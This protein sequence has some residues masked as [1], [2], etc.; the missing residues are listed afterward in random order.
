MLAVLNGPRDSVG[1]VG[2]VRHRHHFPRSSRLPAWRLHRAPAVL[3][4]LWHCRP[5]RAGCSRGGSPCQGVLD[6]LFEVPS[7]R[8]S[9]K[10]PAQTLA[11][12]SK[13]TFCGERCICSVIFSACS[14]LDSINSSTMSQGGQHDAGE[15]RQPA[16]RRI[17]HQA[18]HQGPE[19][20][21]RMAVFTTPGMAGSPAPWHVHRFPGRPGSLLTARTER[22]CC[23]LRGCRA[24]RLPVSAV[25]TAQD[26]QWCRQA[27]YWIVTFI[28]AEARSLDWHEIGLGQRC[29]G[30]PGTA[31]HSCPRKTCRHRSPPVRRPV[32]AVGYGRTDR[33]E[34]DKEIGR[35][36]LMAAPSLPA[37]YSLLPHRASMPISAHI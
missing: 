9:P 23:Q 20:T 11:R 31:R 14:H 1:V 30:P 33:H 24:A 37:E 29:G 18:A 2:C 5:C 15:R 19:A 4:R 8:G 16:Q 36:T 22:L 25:Q 12:S 17:N 3:G 7:C 34:R 35:P 26:A 28:V 21:T 6:A 27:R 10:W 32:A 13:R